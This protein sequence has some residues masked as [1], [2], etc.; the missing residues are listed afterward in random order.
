MVHEG[1]PIGGSHL[2][3]RESEA[4]ADLYLGRSGSGHIMDRLAPTLAAGKG[5]P[6]P[7]LLS[8]RGR[9]TGGKVWVGSLVRAP[10]ERGS[11]SF[12]ILELRI[13]EEE[14]AGPVSR[15]SAIEP[16]GPGCTERFWRDGES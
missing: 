9:R 11:L 7:S 2:R 5:N 13:A 16:V 15:D 4:V 8:Y 10:S 6:W 1:G 3:T 14:A 12:G